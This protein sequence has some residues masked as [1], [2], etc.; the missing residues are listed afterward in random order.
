MPWPARI[1]GRC[2]VL[3]SSSALAIEAEL[4]TTSGRACGLGAAASQSK[5]HDDCCASLV[6]SI[7]TGPGRPLSAMWNASRTAGATS[8]ARVTR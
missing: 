8:C 3:I 4:T 5:S 6:M 1:S 2:A 7:S